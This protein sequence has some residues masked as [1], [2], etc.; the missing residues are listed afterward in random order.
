[1]RCMEYYDG[2]LYMRFRTDCTSSRAY[3]SFVRGP[4]INLGSGHLLKRIIWRQS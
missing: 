3:C 4:D 2:T 1:M